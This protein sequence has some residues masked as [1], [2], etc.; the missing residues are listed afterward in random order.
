MFNRI[1]RVCLVFIA[2]STV[3]SSSYAKNL[4]VR[5][6][7]NDHHRGNSPEFAFQTIERA[8]QAARS[9]DRI[10]VGAGTYNETVE[11]ADR[12]EKSHEFNLIGDPQGKRTGDHGSVTI[13]GGIEV[14]GSN[15]VKIS[16]FTFASS[17]TFPVIWKGSTN[18]LISSCN[19]IGGTRSLLVRDGGLTVV[20]CSFSNFD[21]DAIQVDGDARLSL[22][23]CKIS[24]SGRHGL[25]IRKTSAVAVSGTTIT[26]GGNGIHYELVTDDIVVDDSGDDCECSGTSPLELK[27]KALELLKTLNPES[28]LYRSIVRS[29][30]QH[31]KGSVS[32]SNWTDDWH[33][34]ISSGPEVFDK[35]RSAINLLHGLYSEDVEFEIRDK[36]ILVN[37]PYIAEVKVLGASITSGGTPVPVTAKITVGNKTFQPWGPV[38]SPIRGNVNDR[39]NPRTFESTEEFKASDRIAISGTSW[40]RRSGNGKSD[41]N[42]QSYLSVSSTS[43]SNNVI[44]LRNGSA[45]PATQGFGGQDSAEVFLKPY[46]ADKKIVLNENQ[47]IFLFELGTTSL[48]SSAADFQDLVTLVSLKRVVEQPLTD[49]ELATIKNALDA[50]LQADENLS[51][52]AITEASCGGTSSN[53]VTQALNYHDAGVANLQ[54]DLFGDASSNFKRAWTLAKKATGNTDTQSRVASKSKRRRKPTP[55]LWTSVKTPSLTIDNSS[56]LQNGS[57]VTINS[58]A[59]AFSVSDSHFDGNKT[60]GVQ[61]KSK[62]FKLGSSTMSKNGTGGLL[63]QDYSNGEFRISNLTM[64]DNEDVGVQ[65][66]NSV[67]S[68]DEQNASWTIS[69]SAHLIKT[70]GGHLSLDGVDLRGGETAGV[71]AFMGRLTIENADISDNGYGVAGNQSTIAVSNCVFT[72]NSVG[73]FTESTAS[74]DA[75]RCRFVENEKWGAMIQSENNKVA[76]SNCTL[77]GNGSGLALLGLS[78]SGLDLQGTVISNNT[79]YG[80]YLEKCD[81][82]IDN[83]AASNWRTVGNGR[84]IGSFRSTLTL[85]DV[86][87][88]ASNSHALYSSAS[89]LK[90]KN[91]RLNG[92]SGLYLAEDNATCIADFTSVRATGEKLTGID[93]R[94][95]Q[96]TVRNSILREFQKGMNLLSKTPA[97]VQQSVIASC[98][99]EGIHVNGGAATVTNTIVTGTKRGVGFYLQQGSMSHSNN[100]VYGFSRPFYGTS[101]AA[102]ELMSDPLFVNA[103]TG[104]YHLAAGS[105]AINSGA[106]LLDVTTDFDGNLRPSFKR[107]EMGAYEFMH[108]GG[109]YRV[110]SWT[111]KH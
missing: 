2:L 98:S 75:K 85:V 25:N 58:S 20:S 39:N 3:S 97:V 67:I 36:S 106:E 71:F 89:N 111:E 5:V 68:L 11:I 108:R 22:Q 30:E 95:G 56:F 44:V 8:V 82:T 37:H 60:W 9:G 1:F 45:V 6:S 84:G 66:S 21:T 93:H 103:A 17:T 19:F 50:L 62:R 53:Y 86:A 7:G 40:L 110:L 76:F 83:Q 43:R 42:F 31:I 104:D 92:T 101:A 90:L 55:N 61:L 14:T 15:R 13:K 29:A 81:L 10:Y 80:L 100:I 41:R 33:V 79:V 27:E 59:V 51:E 12:N 35:S 38:N 54:K 46:I 87:V 91:C 94:G 16:G 52:C 73:L 102:T 47:A 72:N 96:L 48:Q 77:D 28:S 105:P 4:Y 88:E 70:V 64:K 74:L 63:V 99:S 109:S 57:G 34:K 49:E 78:G 18:G 32:P 26:G 65:F 69:G 24:G 107:Y 23:N